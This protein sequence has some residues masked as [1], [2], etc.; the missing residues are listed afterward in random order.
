MNL[1]S[2]WSKQRSSTDNTKGI[3]E[4]IKCLKLLLFIG[5]PVCFG[6]DDTMTLG[7]FD[8]S[9][10]QTAE[11]MQLLHAAGVRLEFDGEYSHAVDMDPT[12][13]LRY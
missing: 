1:Y 7:F 5:T 10:T 12:G 2:C 13:F 9:V 6:A 3:D 8:W 11:H 4:Y